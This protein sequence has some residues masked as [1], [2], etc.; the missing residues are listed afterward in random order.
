MILYSTGTV[1]KLYTILYSTGTVIKLYMILYSTGTVITLYM[2]LYSTGTVIFHF[3]LVSWGLCE[4]VRIP[5]FHTDG[6][7]GKYTVNVQCS[8]QYTLLLLYL[9]LVIS[10]CA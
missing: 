6:R 5:Y 4:N 3:S 1:I 10:Y 8:V 9:M 2:I 7:A